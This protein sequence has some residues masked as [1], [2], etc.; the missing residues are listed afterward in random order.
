[1]VRQRIHEVNDEN[2]AFVIKGNQIKIKQQN[3]DLVR[4]RRKEI[5]ERI[6]LV[7]K[8]RLTKPCLSEWNK[9]DCATFIQYKKRKGDAAMPKGLRE[10]QARCV[11]VEGRS[12]P[13]CSVHDSDASDNDDDDVELFGDIVFNSSSGSSI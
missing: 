5:K 4:R 13:D 3:D 12:S 7:T 1:M 11:I 6:D 2:V 9:K 8:L 10:L